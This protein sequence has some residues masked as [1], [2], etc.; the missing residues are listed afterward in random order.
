M[1]KKIIIILIIIV[2]MIIISGSGYFGY[3][4]FKNDQN[5]QFEERKQYQDL[6]EIE[7]LKKEVEELKIDVEQKTIEEKE[8][9]YPELNIEESNNE[10]ENIQSQKV[11]DDEKISIFAKVVVKIVCTNSLNGGATIG[12]G[13]IFGLNRHILTNY[14]VIENMDSCQIGITDDIKN[15][16]QRWFEATVASSIPSLDIASLQLTNPPYFT[17][18]EQ[19]S[20]KT[21]LM[22][23]LVDSPQIST[24]MGQCDTK[25]I[26]LGDP[27]VVI[28]YPSLGGNTITATEGIIS[29]FEGFLIKTS[30][31]LEYGSSGGGAFLKKTNNVCWFG[32]TTAVAKGEL[33]SLGSIINYSLIHEKIYE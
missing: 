29:G 14:H 6:S 13:V 1:N 28:G 10:S 31:K 7:K 8:W 21:G 20:L 23:I 2:G 15:S 33:E 12:S 24:T 22:F 9:I 32:I 26:N 5:Q 19:S 17:P 4:L 11:L 25:D 16:P 30:A 18:I 3:R 27:I